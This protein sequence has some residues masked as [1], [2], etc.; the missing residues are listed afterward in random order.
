MFNLKNNTFNLSPVKL[1]V[2]EYEKNNSSAYSSNK[3]RLFSCVFFFFSYPVYTMCAY[4]LIV[5]VC[6]HYKHKTTVVMVCT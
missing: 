5:I 4:G 1:K 6:G 3:A 2:I